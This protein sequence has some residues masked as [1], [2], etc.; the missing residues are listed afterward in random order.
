[1]YPPVSNRLSKRRGHKNWVRNN[2]IFNFPLLKK[3]MSIHAE[4]MH[5]VTTKINFKVNKTKTT[6]KHLD[7][8]ITMI[9]HYT[10]KKISKNSPEWKQLIYRWMRNKLTMS[11]AKKQ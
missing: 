11:S 6:P 9:F 1:M 3:Y 2:Q 8:Y 10:N 7:R 4:R 5:S